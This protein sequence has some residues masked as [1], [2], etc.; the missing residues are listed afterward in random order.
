M[1]NRNKILLVT[2]TY[3]PQGTGGSLA[4]H[5]MVKLLSK[6]EDL[7]LSVLTGTTNLETV[8]KSN[9]KYIVDPFVRI[10]ERRLPSLSLVLKRY[11]KILENHDVVYIVYAYTFIPVAKMLKKKVIVH[12]HDYKP[13]S[14]SATILSTCLENPTLS[15]LISNS[16]KTKYLE[17]KSI[18]R[19]LLNIGDSL[20]SLLISQWIQDADVIIAVSKRQAE[21][22]AKV[23]PEI[24][25]RL[26]II[27]NPPPPIPQINKEFADKP[28]FIYLGGE[29]YLKGFY[30]LL[31]AVTRFLK[32]GGR[33][34]FIFTNNYSIE[35]ISRITSLNRSYENAI[36]LTGRIPYMELMQIYQKAW[37]LIFPSIW[38]EPLPYAIIESLM[39]QTIPLSSKVGGVS[40]LVE[41]T[42][43]EKFLFNP[44]NSEELYERLLT[45]S[46]MT[47]KDV[48]SLTQHVNKVYHHL[49]H[50]ILNKDNIMKAFLQILS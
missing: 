47:K 6:C 22:L 17:Y 25:G 8:R 23:L 5:L 20:H 30:I 9:V 34:K 33:A 12:L 38:E 31:K 10:I 19:V 43:L 4:T 3:W 7:Q 37:A 1:Q 42:E 18:S 48:L 32:K 36:Q 13:V 44:G 14:P 40:E 16:F 35:Y 27:Y 21:L 11:G 45:V 29:S 28:T 39:T 49:S 2:P 15:K 50:T 24:K 26:K 41:S 46:T